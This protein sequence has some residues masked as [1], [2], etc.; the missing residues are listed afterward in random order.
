MSDDTRAPGRESIEETFRALYGEG[1]TEHRATRD[2]SAPGTVVAGISAY[3]GEDHWHLVTQGLTDLAGKTAG[4]PPNVS[5]FGHELT[6]LTPAADRPPAWAYDLLLGTARVC[7]TVGRAF[8]AGARLAPGAPVDGAASALVAVGLRAD[9]LAKPSAFPFGRYLFLQA[10]GITA[11]EYRL[12]QRASTL[13]VLERL[14]LRD[15]LLRTDPR[16][17]GAPGR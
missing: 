14:A 13:M 12:M 1:P 15:P 6:L 5:R 10:V 16:R 9:P 4:D 3:R 8:H 17:G 11:T 2:P 7:V